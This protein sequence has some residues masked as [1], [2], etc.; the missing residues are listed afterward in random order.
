MNFTPNG[1]YG[2]KAE[3]VDINTQTLLPLIFQR[4]YCTTQEDVNH[5]ILVEDALKICSFVLTA[6]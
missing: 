2:N 6:K 3:T 4:E 1:K 5:S